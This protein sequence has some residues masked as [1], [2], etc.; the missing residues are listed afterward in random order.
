MRRVL[1]LAGIGVA[2]ALALVWALGGFDAL[3]RLATEAQRAMQAPL[4]GAVRAVQAG[5]PAIR[6]LE[7]QNEPGRIQ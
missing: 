5:E 6:S 2:G 7:H 3:G 1:T 4:A